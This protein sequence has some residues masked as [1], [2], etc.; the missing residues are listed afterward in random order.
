MTVINPAEDAAKVMGV[1]EE[2]GIA[3]VPL[4]VA[5]AV[6]GGNGVAIK[7]IFEAKERSL[8]KPNGMMADFE[9][10]SEVHIVDQR[11]RDLVRAVTDDFGLPLSVVAP[12]RM[13]H[14]IFAECDEFTMERSTKLGTLDLLLNAGP[15]HR[16]IT[17]LSRQKMRPV[18]GSSANKSL[19]GSKY[20]LQDVDKEV[21]AAASIEVD[22]GLSR[23]ANARGISS[24]IIDL[25]T[26]E[27]HRYGVCFEQI[28]DILKRYFKI[29][30]PQPK[31][32][33]VA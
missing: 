12:F 4:D 2:G 25:K 6:F 15:L 30:L 11:E 7:R 33:A 27:V 18:L 17:K 32:A 13:D 24:T 28:S 9:I 19:T 14:P 31:T 5:Y 22:Y 21:R 3:I 8:T 29:E 16:E 20:R 23:Y 10:F 1:L 26:F